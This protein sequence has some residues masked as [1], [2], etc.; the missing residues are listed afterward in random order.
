MNYRLYVLLPQ[1]IPEDAEFYLITE[2]YCLL[3]TNGEKP[4]GAKEVQRISNLPDLAKRWLGGCIDELRTRALAQN[5][6]AMLTEIGPAFYGALEQ[7]LAEQ[8]KNGG[9]EDAPT[10]K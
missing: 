7:A 5:G 8:A 10:T 2:K 1:E 9:T 3:Y 4:K 6:D